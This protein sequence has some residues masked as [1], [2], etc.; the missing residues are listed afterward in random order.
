MV[1]GAMSR[2]GIMIIPPFFLFSFSFF[3]F[4]PVSLFLLGSVFSHFGA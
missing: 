4:A 1:Y 3:I 2:L